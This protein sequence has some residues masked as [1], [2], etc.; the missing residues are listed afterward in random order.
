MTDIGIYEII[1]TLNGDRYIGS[2]KELTNREKTHFR[3]LK[4]DNHPNRFLQS[5][6]NKYGSEYFEFNILENC[7]ES[8]L[9]I[10]EQWYLDNTP[11]KYNLKSQAIGGG[12]DNIKL[13]SL[14]DEE[15]VEVFRL[16]HRGLDIR[17]IVKAIGSKKS[18]VNHILNRNTYKSVTIPVEYLKSAKKLSRPFKKRLKCEEVIEIR[19]LKLSGKTNKYLAELYD[20]NIRTVRKIISKESHPDC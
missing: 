11:Y 18:T 1:N 12:F 20:I 3:N 17:D 9:L 14:T 16:R 2:S 4:K 15:V 7:E 10:L 5:A 19:S 6:F 13:R 8:K